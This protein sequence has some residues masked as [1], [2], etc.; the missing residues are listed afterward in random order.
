MTSTGFS[1]RGVLKG[2][3]LGLGAAALGSFAAAPTASAQGRT[4]LVIGSGFGGAVAALRL[5]QA[6]YQTTV[7]E[8]GRRWDIDPGG[9]TFA[10][11]DA[12]DGRAAWF[13]TKPPINP[14]TQF[15][16]IPKYA[17]V[18]EEIK[19]NGIT[20][21]HGAGVGGGSLVFGAYSVQPRRRDFEYAFPTSIDYSE[22]ER[23]YFPRAKK[24]LG[25][26]PLPTDLLARPEYQGARSWLADLADYGTEPVYNDFCVDW[27]LVRAEFA[28]TK[29]KSI[30]IA[31]GPYGINSGAK[32][33]VDHN[34]L[35]RAEA[36]GNVT[37][38]PL[39]E[40]V[41]IRERGD[42]KGFEVTAREIDVDGN[43]LATHTFTADVLFLAAGS[44][45]T[46]ELLVTARATGTLP[47]LSPE[48]GQGFGN[49]GDFL[50]TRVLN[51]HDY[52]PVQAG[53]GIALMYDDED[54][55]GSVSM[56]WQAAPLPALA[57]G[58][59]T[60]HLIQ[61][62]TNE[63]GSID[64]NPATGRVE[65]NYPHPEGGELDQQGMRF[66]GKFHDRASVRHGFPANGTPVYSRAIGFG[67]ASTYHGL[68][69]VVMGKAATDDGRVHGYDNLYVVDGA[70]IPGA[71]GLVNPSLTIT[72][73][74]ERCMD[75]F[76]ARN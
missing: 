12:P 40:A 48:V 22:M 46:T 18:V 24:E 55:A 70:L 7:L 72:A 13:S 17:G 33:S 50:T 21:V 66:A 3:A 37:V 68:G 60:T 47:R 49:N 58:S 28:G 25:T 61:A 65:L 23:V 74:A 67:S 71:V 62:F 59:T 10:T 15:Q 29:R 35:P 63:R 57:S 38:V 2:A 4:A 5:G 43:E 73:V 41:R 76:L 53:P 6:G 44:Y 64:W 11:F 1:R 31:E 51:R 9:N 14:L 69:G 56:S 36:T 20:T 27:D 42:R 19:G 54:P 34:Y 16:P 26:S 45:H 75:R 32:N 30:A 52:G 39:H 8:R